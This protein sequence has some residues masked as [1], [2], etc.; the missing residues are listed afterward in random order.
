MENKKITKADLL[1][2]EDR[3][4]AQ[5]YGERPSEIQAKSATESKKK[6]IK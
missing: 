1:D 4:N 6:H 3:A 2:I 5:G